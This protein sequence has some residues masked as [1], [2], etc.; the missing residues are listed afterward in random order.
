MLAESEIWHVL[1]GAARVRHTVPALHYETVELDVRAGMAMSVA[2]G[3]NVEVSDADEPFI[4]RRMA[5]SCAHNHHADMME[6][7]LAE[8]GVP[9]QL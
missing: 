3:A 1:S 4:V 8:D 5:A 6:R 7:K 2:G 9:A